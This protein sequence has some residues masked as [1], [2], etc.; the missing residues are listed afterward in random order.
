MSYTL[1][2]KGFCC[3][4]P[5]T[6]VYILLIRMLSV[7]MPLQGPR[8]VAG[9]VAVCTTERLGAKRKTLESISRLLQEQGLSHDV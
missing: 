5:R 3:R 1:L 6:Y 9:I 4:L 2:E 8:Y 7:V